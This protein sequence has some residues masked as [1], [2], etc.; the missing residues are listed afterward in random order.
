M[1]NMKFNYIIAIIISILLIGCEKVKDPDTVKS[2]HEVHYELGLLPKIM[3][4]PATPLK[5]KWQLSGDRNL[6]AL[7][8]YSQEDYKFVIENSTPFEIVSNSK[9]SETFYRDWLENK[10]KLDVIYHNDSYEIIGAHDIQPN[11]F[12][13][14]E[15]SPFVNGTVTPLGDGLVLVSLYT[16]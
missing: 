6:Y 16:M 13:Q 1:N 11:L 3:S 12:I 7:L 2:E 8:T 10:I 14:A 5:V 9:L 15:L 4:M